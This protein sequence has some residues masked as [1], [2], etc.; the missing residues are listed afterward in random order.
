MLLPT[1]HYGFLATDMY[2]STAKFA[3][4]GSEKMA[5]GLSSLLGNLGGSAMTDSYIVAEYIESQDMLE[6]I[7]EHLDW[8]GH[9]SRAGAD[10]VS[11]LRDK[12]TLEEQLL[13]WQSVSRVSFDN[14]TGVLTVE[15]R[16]YTPEMAQAVGQAILK[17]SEE[18]MN[19]MNERVQADTVA[20]ARKE[21]ELAEVRYGRARN[22]L[23]SFR[24]STSELNPHATAASRVKIVSELEGRISLLQVELNTKEQF[25]KEDS[26]TIRALRES[27]EELQAQL[28]LEKKLLTGDRDPELLKVLERYEAL[29]LENEFARKYYVT[30]LASLEAARVQSER[31]SIYLEAFQAPTLPDEAVY[32]QRGRAIL[33]SIVVVGMGFALI[34]LIIAAVKEHIGV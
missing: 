11:R 26:F 25:L 6:V 32:P 18:L 22:A 17:G 31:K 9:Y 34:M 12:A 2:V 29:S 30:A 4:R 13:Y 21:V 33:L 15:V 27:L 3:V 8:V 14:Q 24:T 28:E 7:K 10:W 16:A 19:R 23:N 20:Q 1:I 5:G